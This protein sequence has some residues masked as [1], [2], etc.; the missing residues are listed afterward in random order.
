MYCSNTIGSINK[1][2][3]IQINELGFESQLTIYTKKVLACMGLDSNKLEIS[4]GTLPVLSGYSCNCYFEHINIIVDRFNIS[5]FQQYNRFP[6]DLYVVY[7]PYVYPQIFP[8]NYSEFKL[9]SPVINFDAIIKHNPC[10][11]PP[12]TDIHYSSNPPVGQTVAS[13]IIEASNL[14][15]KTESPDEGPELKRRKSIRVIKETEK[16]KALRKTISKTHAT[17]PVIPK[18]EERIEKSNKLKIHKETTIEKEKEPIFSHDSD[19]NLLDFSEELDPL[20]ENMDPYPN[21]MLKNSSE[22]FQALL[23]NLKLSN[24]LDDNSMSTFFDREMLYNDFLAE[25][26]QNQRSLWEADLDE[27]IF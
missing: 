6:I 18:N 3:N 26:S 12:P 17:V 7:P 8:V 9:L 11:V 27:F 13:K 21:S 5:H 16:A 15:R 4:V 23:S 2:K 20:K 22:P 1:T 25:P 19:I 14:K 24:P 10:I